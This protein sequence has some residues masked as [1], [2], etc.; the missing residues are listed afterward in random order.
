[1]GM[2]NYKVKYSN[3]GIRT[4]ESHPG[5]IRDILSPH[6]ERYKGGEGVIP[7]AVHMKALVLGNPNLEFTSWYTSTLFATNGDLIKI[8]SP[9]SDNKGT[10]TEA[11]KLSLGI[12]ASD[13]NCNNLD[14]SDWERINGEG[15]YT[16]SI[17]KWFEKGF[18]GTLNFWKEM[19]EQHLLNISDD[20]KLGSVVIEDLASYFFPNMGIAMPREGNLPFL[21]F[22]N[23]RD[24]IK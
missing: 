14:Y 3:G 23:Y 5:E 22:P 1:M 21:R 8:I 13:R 9:Y 6:L 15:V 10:L 20:I 24:N 17:D 16:N 7:S 12:I 2:E 18:D 4:L 11:A 19:L